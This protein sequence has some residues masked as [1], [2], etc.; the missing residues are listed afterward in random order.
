MKYTRKDFGKDLIRQLRTGYDVA[1]LSRWAYSVYL[2]R[3]REMD[4][5]LDELVM[6]IVAMEEGPEFEFS[7]QELR[8]MA[9]ELVIGHD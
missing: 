2:E 9:N 3:C 1:R 4:A 7:E 8:R 5:G 6:S